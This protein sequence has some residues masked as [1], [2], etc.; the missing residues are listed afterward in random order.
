M[1]LIINGLSVQILTR[2][3][4]QDT[5]LLPL[6]LIA[7]PLFCHMVNSQRY[8]SGCAQWAII[9]FGVIKGS[10]I[11]TYLSEQE[12]S[13]KGNTWKHPTEFKIETN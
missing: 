4:V 6:P 5:S 11:S 13:Y 12:C 9:K 1:C 3:T 7:V 8:E 10:Q 2:H